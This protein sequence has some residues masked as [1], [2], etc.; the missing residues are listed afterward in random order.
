MDAGA[1]VRHQ[2]KQGATSLGVRLQRYRVTTDTDVLVVHRRYGPGRIHHRG[3]TLA[4]LHA[5]FFSEGAIGFRGVVVDFGHG[6]EGFLVRLGHQFE[7]V[8]FRQLAGMGKART[9]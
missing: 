6:L 2:E 9:Q 1:R 5:T 3:Q 4:L 7:P 8:G